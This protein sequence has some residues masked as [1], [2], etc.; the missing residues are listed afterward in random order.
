MHTRLLLTL[1]SQTILTRTQNGPVIGPIVGGFVFQALG[2]RWTNWVVM[3][4]SGASF[5]LVLCMS[6]PL[7]SLLPP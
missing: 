4:G 7:N 6:N 5:F 2:W 1:R 3:I